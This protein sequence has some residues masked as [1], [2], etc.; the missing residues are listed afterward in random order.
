MIDTTSSIVHGYRSGRLSADDRNALLIR[1]AW[2]PRERRVVLNGFFGRLTIGFEPLLCGAMFFALTIGTLIVRTDPQHPADHNMT[3]LAPVF[4]LG[5]AACIAYFVGVMLAPSR[6][7]YHTL[8]PIFIVDGY[9]RHRAPDDD[10]PVD[11]NGYVAVLTDD[12][13]VACEWP[14]LGEIPL[15][16]Y[17]APAL[18]EF[19]VYGGVHRIDGRS[20][21]VLPDKI[22][23]FGVGIRSRREIIP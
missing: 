17:M 13:S 18:C 8:R 6:A 21:G 11:S 1:R 19:T 2:T 3:I 10:S 15:R 9:V 4:G 23:M 5:V 7:L 20:T 16:P 14:T 22:A 12:K